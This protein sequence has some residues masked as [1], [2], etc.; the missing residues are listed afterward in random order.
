MADS[1][2][3]KCLESLLDKIILKVSCSRFNSDEER[4]F[5]ISSQILTESQTTIR[6]K[7]DEIETQEHISK[8]QLPERPAQ[9]KEQS[10]LNCHVKQLPEQYKGFP[11]SVL[12]IHGTKVPMRACTK[13]QNYYS[14]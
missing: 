9:E 7:W 10:L 12:E 11:V 5:S 14:P 13:S 3:G 4:I 8:A 1:R 6:E 2:E